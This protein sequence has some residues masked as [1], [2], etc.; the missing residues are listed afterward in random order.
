MQTCA[1]GQVPV[2]SVCVSCTSPCSTCIVDQNTC[3]TCTTGYKYGTKCVTTCP[4]GMAVVSGACVGCD[5]N[6]AS[7]SSTNLAT[8]F[9]CKANYLILNNTCYTSCPVNY[10]ADSAK[11]YC[12]YVPPTTIITNTTTIIVDHNVTN[13]VTVNNTV[14][15]IVNHTITV[16]VNNTVNNT[17]YVNGTTTTTTI[18]NGGSSTSSASNTSSN[19]SILLYFPVTTT[20]TI[21]TGVAVGSH[22]KCPTSNVH[23]S[24]LGLWGPLELVAYGA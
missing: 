7:C 14:T 21:L 19:G 1:S 15:V 18:S 3:V 22:F 2:N 24:M 13:N 17:V 12:T 20:Q 5:P 4:S 8:C 6:C 11:T 16:T 9:A 23:S 10:V